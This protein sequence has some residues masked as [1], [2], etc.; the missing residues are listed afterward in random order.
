MWRVLF[1]LHLVIFLP[2]FV[3]SGVRPHRDQGETRA[4]Q[5]PQRVSRLWRRPRR[6]VLPHH[7]L[8][9]PRL[10]RTSR[11]LRKRGKVSSVRVRI[12]F[13]TV[14]VSVLVTNLLWWI[15]SVVLLFVQ[16][17]LDESAA[18]KMVSQ[19]LKLLE[20]FAWLLDCYVLDFFVDEHWRKIPQSW[21][22]TLRV[23][24]DVVWVWHNIS[25]YPSS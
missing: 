16:M 22:E 12:S 3:D 7:E 5:E 4:S 13:Y 24:E 6:L 9:R 8:P 20:N 25:H 23:N 17:V 14:A 15:I 10:D 18:A 2:L 21:Q 11:G 1:L 19:C